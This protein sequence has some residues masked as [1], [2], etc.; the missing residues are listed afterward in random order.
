MSKKV[1][2]VDVRRRVQAEAENELLRAQITAM[3]RTVAE[4]AA[5]PAAPP[6]APAAPPPGPVVPPVYEAYSKITNQDERI[7]F[8][9]QVQQRDPSAYVA[10]AQEIER[11]NTR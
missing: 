10:L 11:R 9:V 3:E 7:M 2:E 6:P 1:S 5:R 8:V 4:A